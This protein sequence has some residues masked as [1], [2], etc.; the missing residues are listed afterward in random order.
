MCAECA[1][2]LARNEAAKHFG[3][4]PLDAK[5]P[6]L[7]GD[8]VKKKTGYGFPGVV[9][10][11][12][13]NLKGDERLVVECIVPGVLGM[14]HI[15]NPEQMELDYDPRLPASQSV[16]PGTSPAADGPGRGV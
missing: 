10:A 9:V 14:L 3:A 8:R 6:F 11:V 2:D 4:F 15:F 1:S 13:N 5:R 12:F 7:V 16:P